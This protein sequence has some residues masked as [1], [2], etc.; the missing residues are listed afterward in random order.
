MNAQVL[1]GHRHEVVDLE[2]PQRLGVDAQG[3]SNLNPCQVVVYL[4]PVHSPS[5]RGVRTRSQ[6]T[7]G[8]PARGLATIAPDRAG[9]RI[10]CRLR[11]ASRSARSAVGRR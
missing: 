1:E 10:V 8:S 11:T 9:R 6:A 4:P 3:T 7:D 2:V 5:L